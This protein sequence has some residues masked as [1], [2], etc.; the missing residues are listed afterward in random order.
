MA[1]LIPTGWY[2][3]AVLVSADGKTLYVAN[4]K[5]HGSLSQP[6]PKE[7]GKNSHD[8]LGSVSVIDVPDAAQLAKYTAEVNANNRLAY[9][10]AGLEKPRPDAKPVPVPPRHGEPS[11]VQARHLHHQGEPH[12]RSGARRHEGGQ[13]RSETGACSARR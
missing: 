11:R 12:L 10:L 8:H 7:K 2:P 4:I 3:G 13:R 9:S 6:R 5:G 1:G